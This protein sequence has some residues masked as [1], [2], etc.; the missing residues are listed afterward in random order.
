MSTQPEIL[1]VE[2]SRTQAEAFAEALRG[3]GYLVSTAVN[4]RA[5]L[6]HLRAH[7]VQ[8]IV[9]DVI[10]PEMDGYELCRQIRADAALAN[11]PVLLLTQLNDPADIIKGLD[12]GADSFMIKDSGDDGRLLGRVESLLQ[13]NPADRQQRTDPV[14]EVTFA[15]QQYRLASSRLPMLELLL[16]QYEESQRQHREL[17]QTHTQLRDAFQAIQTL[18]Q[19]MHDRSAQTQPRKVERIIHLLIAE[20]SPTQ[21]ASLQ[22]MLEEYGYQVRVANNGRLA[23]DAIREHKPDLVISDVV[24]PEMDGFDFCRAL[25]DDPGL[26]DIPVV[27]LT[28]LSDPQDIVRGLS[29]RTDYYLT[30]PFDPIHLLTR[31]E[32]LLANPPNSAEPQSLEAVIG[33]ENTVIQSDP[34]HILNLLLATYEQ[35]VTQNRKLQTAERELREWNEQLEQRVAERTASLTREVA[36]RRRAAAVLQA[37]L[38]LSDY[39][40]GHSLEEL[41]RL[42]LDEA[43]LLTGSVIG[44]AHFVEADQISLSL[45][46]WSTNTLQ[47][48][49]TAEGARRHYPAD[50]AGVWADA[51]RERRPVIHNDYA[52][53]THRKGLP[54]GHSPVVRLVVVPV[55]RNQ[56]VVA[57]VG[58]GNKALEYVRADVDTVSELANLAWDVVLTKRADQATRESEARFGVMADAAPVLIWEAGTDKLCHYFNKVWLDFT[59]RTLEHEPGNRW[60]EGVHPDDRAGCLEIYT[61]SFDARREFKMEYRLRR[62][63]GEYRWLL[64]HGVPRFQSDGTFAGYIGSCVDITDRKGA[65]ETLRL[66]EHRHRTILRTTQDGFWRVDLQG[67]M[68]EVNP[69]YC[70]MS[71]YSEAELLSMHASV[72]EAID[73][74]TDMVA[75]IQRILQHGSA[76]FES[77]HR[78]KDGT[79]FPVEISAQYQPGEGGQ[80]IVFACDI[81]LRKQAEEQL[82]E[83]ERQLSTLMGNLPGMAYRCQNDHD[84]T[85]SFV[86]QGCEELTGYPP[87]DLLGNQRVTYASLIVAE[88]Q[89]PVWN[90]VQKAVAEKRPFQLSYRIRS[91]AG[92]VKWVWEQGVGVF[93]AD[94]TLETLEGFIADVNERKKAEEAMREE[95]VFS[96]AVVDSIPGTF[97]AF[98]EDGRYVRWNAYQRDKIVGQPDELVSRTNAIETIH[99][100]DRAQ[101]AARIGNVFSNGQT[102]TVEGRVLLRGGPDFRWFLMTGNLMVL[103]G[104]RFLVGIGLDVT[105]RKQTESE[106]QLS[107]SR[108]AAAMEQAQLA[109][110]ERDDATNTFTF[111]DRFYALYGTTGEREGG[112]QMPAEVYAREFLPA[113]EQHV[114]AD[115]VARLRLEG[116]D[117]F[118][119]EHRIRRRDGELRH[120]LVRTTAIRDAAGR[121][122]GTRGTNQDITERKL[123]EDAASLLAAIVEFS[124]DAIYSRNLDGNITT[125]NLGAERLFGYTAA[126]MVGASILRLIPEDRLA[127]EHQILAEIK[128]GRPLQHFETIRRTKDGRRM[129]VSVTASPI[130]DA[131]GNII[132][133]SKV[134]R[135]ITRQKQAAAALRANEEILQEVSRVAKVG[136]WGLDLATQR[137]SWTEETRRIHEVAPDYEPQLET[138]I[139][140]YAPPARPVLREAIESA[141]AD[142]VPFD[143]E[144]PLITAKGKPLWVRAIGNLGKVEGKVVRLYGVFQDITETKATER[145]LRLT[146]FAMEQATDEVY[147]IRED[148]GFQFVNDAA[149]RALELDREEL[150]NS[151]MADID[152][153][154]NAASWRQHWQ[155]LKAGG[156][157]TFETSHRSRSGRVYPVEVHA[158]YIEHEGEAYSCGFCRDITERKRAEEA[159]RTT[160]SDLEDATARANSLAAQAECASAAK[161]EFLANMSHEIRTPLNGVLGMNGLML[162]TDL[163]DEQRGYAQTVR[164]SGEGLLT[165]LNDILD[166]S[167][168]EAGRLD[169][170]ILDFNLHNLL[171]DF[172]G[173]MAFR[174]HEKSLAFGCVTAPEVPAELHGDPGR[175]RQILTNLTGNAIKFTA[176]GEVI[177][178]VRVVSETPVAVQL[179]FGV[180]DTGIG[181][182]ADKMGKLYGKFSQVDSSTT[183]V[184]GGTGLGLAISK[185]LTELM[186]GEVGVESEV[187]KGSEFW[188]TVRLGKSTAPR[189]AAGPRLASLHGK[190]ILVVDDRPVNRE[191]LLGLLNSWGLRPAEAGDGP[192]ALQAL[193]AAQAAQDPFALAILDLHLPGMD[194]NSLGRAIKGDPNLQATRLVLCTSMGKAGNQADWEETGFVAALDKPVRR[195]ELLATLEAAL[196]GKSATGRMRTSA[197]SAAKP[198]LPHARIL[199]A[200]D[201]ITNQQVAA[202]ILRKLG[203]TAEVVANGLEAIQA[204]ETIP[205]DLVLMDVQ[206]PELDGLAATRRIRDPQSRVL[207]PRVPII[208]MT[209]HAMQ[210]DEQKCLAAGM[211]GYVPKPVEV[212]ALIAA[213][214]K[215]LKPEAESAATVAAKAAEEP[216]AAMLKTKIPIFERSSLLNRVMDDEEMAREVIAGFLEDLPRQI[217]QLKT[218]VAAGE[219]P[220]AGDQAHKIKGACATV[221]GAAMSALAATLEQAG[222]AGDLHTL[223]ARLPE[224]DAQFKA[225]QEAIEQ[226]L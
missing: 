98:G 29:A 131:S 134:A 25:K 48:M 171:D 95:Q 3:A 78:R 65:E 126:E 192:A 118:Q 75:R 169:L 87:A 58:V 195:Q 54:P 143:L 209:A 120:I 179:R 83:R 105:D 207:N 172:L 17:I 124:E 1:I 116:M 85:M 20:D 185:Q 40:P 223:S 180:S 73:T 219:A 68:L 208:A 15:K 147:F 63:D 206:M 26:K 66:S 72:V 41:L 47:K 34:Q 220:N 28:A 149:C 201:N 121:A 22:A 43:E 23:L 49:C 114:V 130:K 191:I 74:A 111:N 178:R 52:S 162:E 173:M 90:E 204:L 212:S 144:L 154:Y 150:L 107:Q 109:H 61:T 64:D 170:E 160:I 140:F 56:Q 205:Y 46:T 203:M 202:G 112:Y 115:D 218:F 38:R 86:S 159:L 39:A 45:Q 84:W 123:A 44:F 186:G 224:V 175:L 97:Y 11:L 226:E 96:K 122:V 113:E 156:A 164:S 32:Y 221:G 82:R 166:F 30:K 99:P 5:A 50:E 153:N 187:G 184:F 216:V 193:A 161:S 62:H 12:C 100:D 37:R 197:D 117:G 70:Q 198:R 136:G 168:I 129:D 67:R 139:H 93:A 2:D 188:F 138:A 167:K 132:G 77:R 57:L 81:T 69:A 135:D 24:M 35:S 141:L 110:W 211:D 190:R 163:T 80:I 119:T 127:E 215:W 137:L 183:R 165:L 217:W 51:L 125:W 194:G 59:G 214:K 225:L 151:T 33:G 55:L 106:L 31:V 13:A 213:L 103:H 60:A 104:K 102:E 18:S 71:G 182:P 79:E 6:A 133:V 157:L 181:I 196:R 146:Q 53:L 128:Q 176:Q 200:E 92:A 108:L 142:E 152:P 189:S 10:M 101:I 4:G 19:L 27:L 91:A 89:E 145:L 8:L 76:R 42:T 174:A 36:E 14:I 16:A 148:A 222:K 158:N 210:G 94:G 7:P 88:D 21:A 155:E 9:S 177:I 199:V